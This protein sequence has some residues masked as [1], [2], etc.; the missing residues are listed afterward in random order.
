MTIK[1][2]KCPKSKILTCIIHEHLRC[3]Q[4]GTRMTLPIAIGITD[5]HRFLTYLKTNFSMLHLYD[6]T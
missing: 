5:F 3:F 1:V 6:V 4:I 2:T